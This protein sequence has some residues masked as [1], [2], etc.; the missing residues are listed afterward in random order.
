VLGASDR[1]RRAA[2]EVMLGTRWRP[3]VVTHTVSPVDRVADVTVVVVRAGRAITAV[4][5]TS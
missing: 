3:P 1:A 5:P 2:R 4:S